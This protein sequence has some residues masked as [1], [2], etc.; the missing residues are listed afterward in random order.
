M[1]M[2]GGYESEFKP[3]CSRGVRGYGNIASTTDRRENRGGSHACRR[4]G[5]RKNG[6]RDEPVRKS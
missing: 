4:D 6:G 3:E 1:I 2:D 5:E